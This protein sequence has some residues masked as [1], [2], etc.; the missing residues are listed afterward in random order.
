MK[1]QRE[2][3]REREREKE[4]EREN[5]EKER[6]LLSPVTYQFSTYSLTD[7][8]KNTAVRVIF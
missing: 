7:K 8:R 5:R 2:R 1:I 3:E 4:R 6:V